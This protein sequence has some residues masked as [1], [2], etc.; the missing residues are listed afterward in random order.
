MVASTSAELLEAEIVVDPGQADAA[1]R[2]VLVEQQARAIDRAVVVERDRL[3][4]V[5]QRLDRPV[6][7]LQADRVVEPGRRVVGVE[8]LGDLELLGVEWAAALLE[9]GLAEVAAQQ[10]G[11]G[12]ERCGDLELAAA[13]L[14]VARADLGEAEAEAGERHSGIQLDR[15]LERRLR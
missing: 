2:Q 9:V 4:D 5:A 7:G 10:R 8:L 12:V 1:G 14:E 3:F 13:I 6:L 11:V 15:A